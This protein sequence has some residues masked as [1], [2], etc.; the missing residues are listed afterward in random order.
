M[1]KRLTAYLLLAIT[2][3]LV[4]CSRDPN[5]RKL[6]YFES[7]Q[8]Y[9]EKGKYREAFIQFSNAVQVD[10][11]Y[12]DAHYHLAQACLRLERW[13]P[14]YEELIKTLEIQ[15]WNYS[16]HLD[17]ANLL[18]AA[19]D[20]KQAQE[21]V[22]VLRR[23]QTTNPMVHVA[24]A[25]LYAAQGNFKDA[26][27]E[28]QRAI[29]LTP[30][31]A[32]YYVAL[33]SLQD[34][35]SQPEAAEPNFRKAVE[36]NPDA[37]DARLA[38][39]SYYQ[40]RGS[41]AEAEQQVGTA[42]KAQPKNPDLRAVLVRLY[43][44][45]GRK[46]A[47]IDFARHTRD[48]FPDSSA[49]YRMLG[50]LY[51]ATGDYANALTEY[52]TLYREHPSDLQVKKN[53]VQ[54]LIIENRLDEADKLN[55]EILK[56]NRNEVDALVDLG[57]IQIREGKSKDAV[58]TLQS[59]VK[60]DPRN[61]LAYYHLG[62][63]FEQLGSLAQADNCWQNAVR[64]RPDL[65]EAHLALAKSALRDGDMPALEQSAAQI[66]R[67]LPNSPAGY[68]M[69]A[70]SYLKRGKFDKAEQDAD[71]AISL[72]PQSPDG[73][74]Q[75]GNLRL[76]QKD[77]AQAEKFYQKTLECDPNSADALGSL[78]QI[79]V[80]RKETQKAVA[81]AQAQIAKV[82]NSSAFYD[83][84]GTTRFDQKK[85]ESDIEAAESDLKKATELD[86]NDA[87]AWLKLS[88]VQAARGRVS[89]AIATSQ[90]ALLDNPR[91][92]AFY[93][94][95]GRLYEREGDRDKA[96]QS[97]Q[98]ALQIDPRN[99]Q[100]SNNLAR[101]IAQTGGNLDLALS[102][103]QTARRGLPDSSNAADTLGWVFYQKGAYKSAIDSFQ[104]ALKL[105]DKSRSPENPTLHY[106]L[107]LAYTRNG[108][109]ALARQ[110]LERVLRIDPNAAEAG[111]V[112]KLLG[113][114]HG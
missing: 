113:Q 86:K 75:M 16:A 42:I 28:M 52:A 72:A 64:F 93:V 99:P 62:V 83:L 14:A 110:H 73:Y 90:Q 13:T 19:R 4:G 37:V 40:S 67:L 8:R 59:A 82:P 48:G 106:H 96:K 25:N 44:F 50:D 6:K 97:Y 104:E 15:K 9:F 26:I 2:T 79:Y 57:Q 56:S 31:R 5:V 74:M 23:E 39:A 102:L 30:D 29:D 55:S 88:Q 10:P 76:A 85:T 18:I 41:F 109:N 46:D 53:Y 22:D 49:G 107:G 58:E 1:K 54:L 103:A 87:D 77:Y 35:I 65:S 12:A 51:F 108:Q 100:A 91:Q 61:G 78:M 20:F 24:A 68:A 105:A 89:E 43:L 7:G 32:E 66:I 33:A 70:L 112:R 92:V 38:L 81:L 84:L 80:T 114:L 95:I 94:L 21:H 34:Q 111:D 63:A 45:E 47:A 27:P 71:K 17:L 60:V 98:D 11:G 36:L 101:V 69:R 3:F